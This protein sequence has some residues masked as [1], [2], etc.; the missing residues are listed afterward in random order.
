MRRE[1]S[2]AD[3]IR[4]VAAGSQ[5]AMRM[6]FARHHV[7]VVRFL[8]RM[9]GDRALAEELCNDAFIE[10]WRKAGDFQFRSSLGTWILGIAR[11][12]ALNAMRR[13]HHPSA[14]EGE[15]EGLAD[16]ADTPEITAQKSSKAEML[17]ACVD[18]LG[19][20]QRE[21]VDLAYYHEKTVAEIADV[22]QIPA[23]TVKSRM[24]QARRSLSK[25]MADRGIDRG[26]P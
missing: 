22:L 15:A 23:N 11:Y 24:F 5:S 3:L 6:I 26:W 2:D 12:K 4:Q 17:R 18:A 20:L 10:V 7:A 1:T 25:M 13:R 21:I 16:G 14:G 8:T 19:P 9:T